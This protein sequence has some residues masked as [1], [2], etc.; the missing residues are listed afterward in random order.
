MRFAI[1]D[2]L[3]DSVVDFDR[4]DLPLATFLPEAE[5]AALAPHRALLEPLHADLATGLVHLAVQSFVLRAG[6]R[7]I[8][9]DTCVGE[10]KDRASR[11]DWHRR[12]ATGFLAR[13]AEAGVAPGQ[14]DAVFCT[15]LHA[16]HVGWNTRL[17]NG[18]W[19][20]TFPRARY[21][22]G[23]AEMAHFQALHAANPE[24]FPALTDSVLP[25]VQ[26][27][28]VDLV[29]DGHEPADGVVLSPLPGHT[30]GQ[31]GLSVRSGGARALFCGDAVH[32]PI[33][34]LHPDCSTAF[35]TDRPLA[36]ATRQALLED[37]A[38]SQGWLVPAHFRRTPRARIR[39]AGAG[40]VP[41]LA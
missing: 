39:A 1:G 21:L 10:H 3:V 24:N 26:A 9:I 17:E 11:P 36:A 4:F 8:L 6:G 40:F 25:V 22:I 23:R 13:L 38:E 18:A 37:L 34:I 16:D 32:S 5:P 14:V 19:V 27:G 29:D 30:P 31:M 7:T 33:Q 41:E 12:D 35:C 28:Q 20:P 2:V 15:H